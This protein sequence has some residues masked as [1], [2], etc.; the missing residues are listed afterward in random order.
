V[1]Y[2]DDNVLKSSKELAGLTKLKELKLGES[3]GKRGLVF[4]KW[5]NVFKLVREIDEVK[6][7]IDVKNY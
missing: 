5:E 7:S 4:F 2:L 6:S 3:L 1:L